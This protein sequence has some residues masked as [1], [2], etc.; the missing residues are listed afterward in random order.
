MT[1]VLN[2]N[3]KLRLT[4][5]KPKAEYKFLLSKVFALKFAKI[6]ISTRFFKIYIVVYTYIFMK[7]SS[8]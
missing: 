7:I 8:I 4:T 5:V 1:N 6:I 3:L 2:L